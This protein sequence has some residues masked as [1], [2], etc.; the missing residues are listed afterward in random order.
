LGEKPKRIYAP[1]ELDAV[2]RRLRVSDPEEARRM[3]QI[4]GGEIGEERLE[5]PSKPEKARLG[6]PLRRVELA[7]EIPKEPVRKAK[8]P[9]LADTAGFDKKAAYGARLKMD[10]LCAHAEYQIKTGGSVIASFFSFLINPPDL[11]NPDFVLHGLGD[12]Y[13]HIERL[14]LAVRQLARF[15]AEKAAEAWKRAHPGY[16]AIVKT[17]KAWDLEGANIELARLQRKPRE[18][19][20]KQT[21]PLLRSLLKPVFAMER[22]DAEC[23]IPAALEALYALQ[24]K[25][26]PESARTQL[27]PKLGAALDEL[28]YAF[29]RMPRKLYP[30][31]L[32][33]CS[34]EFMN[35][36]SLLRKR[37]AAI[38]DLCGLSEQDILVGLDEYP[39]QEPETGSSQEADAEAGQEDASAT[40]GGSRDAS[41]PAMA[42]PIEMVDR[43]RKAYESLETLFPESGFSQAHRFPDLFPYFRDILDLP[44][45]FA[46]VSPSDPMQQC[47]ILVS[48]I[49]RFFYGFRAVSFGGAEDVDGH[50]VDLGERIDALI[51]RWHAHEDM[52]YKDYLKLL[53]DYC[54]MVEI[55]PESR[56][57]SFGKRLESEIYWLKR[58]HIL[59]KLRP[60]TLM[61][62]KPQRH[63]D[64]PSLWED[65]KELR[66]L[67][68][69][70][71]ADIDAALKRRAAGDQSSCA[72][73]DNPW[74][75]YQF[76]V[77]NLVSQRLDAVLARGK[78][79]ARPN[80]ASLVYYCLSFAAALDFLLNDPESWAYR[81]EGALLYRSQDP[82]GR[83]PLYGVDE[84]IDAEAIFKKALASK[85][86]K[87]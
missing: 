2:R 36:E 16:R 78:E 68:A 20:A 30:L 52:I 64:K 37:R 75:P 10:R 26:E 85:E 18:V 70:V 56:M 49:K 82:E 71:G 34:S 6:K 79:G 80:N 74:E 41:E 66:R 23:D 40:D 48:I 60:A 22:I 25:H 63:G 84:K 19:V 54:R 58:L 21:R 32:K 33:L 12:M 11:L 61:G 65:A 47:A 43:I 15:K 86:P 62:A 31:V 3:S 38:L 4:L 87:P 55:S 67:L 17:I 51:D 83:I 77:P 73:I 69:R 8:A 44:S 27:K 28:T 45:G 53:T 5:E 24:A 35:W 42:E 7:P 1:G 81:E 72:T 9:S 76:Q 50:P 14:A 59:P 46:L 13:R 39:P 29:G 57:S